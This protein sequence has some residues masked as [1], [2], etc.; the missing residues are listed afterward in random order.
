MLLGQRVPR[1]AKAPTY[2]FRQLG[3]SIES[4]LAVTVRKS[5]QVAASYPASAPRR[6]G[7]RVAAPL[8][9]TPTS[10]ILHLV[11]DSPQGE[12]V[13]VPLNRQRIMIGDEV[14]EN[15]E[16]MGGD[17]KRATNVLESGVALDVEIAPP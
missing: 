3:A 14:T 1:K 9:E 4:L 15:E 17:P 16:P 2:A 11:D 6:L 5:V 13:V 7:R 10:P 12:E 8:A